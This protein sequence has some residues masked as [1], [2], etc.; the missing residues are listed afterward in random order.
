MKGVFGVE[1]GRPWKRSQDLPQQVLTPLKETWTCKHVWFRTR[2][3]Q[4]F[5]ES[6]FGDMLSLGRILYSE[7]DR[8]PCNLALASVVVL[9]SPPPDGI[10]LIYPRL[11]ERRGL[12]KDSALLLASL[13]L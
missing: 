12:H 3:T 11:A 7:E 2:Q 10:R 13:V 9:A 4:D 5:Y 1:G 8:P 6:E